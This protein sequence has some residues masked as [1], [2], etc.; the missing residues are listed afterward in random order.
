VKVK[1]L[2]FSALQYHLEHKLIIEKDMLN[3]LDDELNRVR[4]EKRTRAIKGFSALSPEGEIV[5]ASD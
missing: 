2:W 5:E 4:E 3:K 1:N